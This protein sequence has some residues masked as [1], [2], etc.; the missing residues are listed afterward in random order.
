MTLFKAGTDAHACA[1]RAA[2]T[3]GSQLVRRLGFIDNPW[4]E[5]ARL[6]TKSTSRLEDKHW[7][8]IM[9]YSATYIS[10]YSDDEGSADEK[11]YGTE[12]Q[13]HAF[14]ELD[15]CVSFLTDKHIP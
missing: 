3:D 6:L 4:G 11:G 12:T 1:K 5:K 10:G 14:I 15:W 7:A 13:P 8:M 9:A 2:T